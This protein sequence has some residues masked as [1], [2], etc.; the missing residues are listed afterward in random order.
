M[1]SK[2]IA[3]DDL[4]H[5][6]E[7]T[8][9]LWEEMRNQRLFI[10]GGTGF[11][12]C[13]LL[14]T[15]CYINHKLN[16]NARVTIL[17]RSPSSFALKAPH[18]AYDTSVS[19]L[20]GDVRTFEFPEG[21][22]RFVIH[23]ATDVSSRLDSNASLD[24]L[25]SILLG[26]QRTLEFAASHQTSRFLLAS[27][28]AVY[29]KQPSA[30]LNLPETYNG[31]PDPLD[32]RSAYSEGKRT[33]EL[34]CALFQQTTGLNCAI[35]RCWA[36]CG[37]YLPLDGQFAIG[38]FIGDVLAG[39]PIL[40]KG[41]GTARRS[42]LYG[43]DLAVWLWTML[44]R[45]PALIPINV[46]SSTEISMLEL[47]KMVA[48]TLNPGAVIRVAEQPSPDA[49]LSRYVPSVDRA[50]DLLGLSETVNLRESIRRTADWYDGRASDSTDTFLC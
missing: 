26:T 41:D 10:T 5:V 35:A 2:R 14:E 21:E 49:N 39:R 36:F 50:R 47:A 42:Y 19:L 48:E 9:S 46:G 15:F 23:A 8:S 18:I 25:S 32:P 22:F 30:L 1:N 4:E 7:G 28:G 3:Q 45:G 12:G 34:L 33:A 11:F 16:L 37:P 24:M 43:S 44:F 6:L 17:T 13:W 20:A 38:N 40:I 29:G 27:S 31:A